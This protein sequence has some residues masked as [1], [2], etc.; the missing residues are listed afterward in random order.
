MS[1]HGNRP[2]PEV[3]RQRELRAVELRSRGWLQQAI[4]DDLGITVQALRKLFKRANAHT[5]K[6]MVEIA[7]AEK[8]AQIDQLNWIAAEASRAWTRSCEPKKVTRKRSGG[9]GAEITTQSAETKPGDGRL[10]KEMRE[11]LADKRKLLGLDIAPAP[12]AAAVDPLDKL[13]P[14]EREQQ[15]AR[16]TQQ[17]ADAKKKEEPSA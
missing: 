1:G 16:L 2:A 3:T 12:Q 7:K 9:N 5:L 4:A 14:E 6:Q 15:I 11:A 13:S 8:V 17:L 10:L